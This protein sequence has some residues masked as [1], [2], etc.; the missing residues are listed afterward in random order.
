MVQ[1]EPGAQPGSGG[2]GGAAAFG[3]CFRYRVVGLVLSAYGSHLVLVYGS[4][5]VLS[6]YGLNLVLSRAVAEEG[7]QQ[8]SEDQAEVPV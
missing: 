6:V 3:M 2:G 5:L 4:G 8:H 1:I 7:E